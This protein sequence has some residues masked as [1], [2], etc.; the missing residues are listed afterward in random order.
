[1][2]TT[3]ANSVSSTASRTYAVQVDGS[4]DLVVNV[5]WVDTDTNTDTTYTAGTGLTLSGTQFSV[6][7][8]YVLNSGDSIAGQLSVT[9][10]AYPPLE[11]TRDA[12][13]VTTGNYGALK[14]N[15]ST[16]G[17]PQAGLGSYAG[18][19]VDDVIKG[20]VGFEND[21]SFHILNASDADLFTISSSG[22]FGINDSTP[23]YKL[24]INGASSGTVARITAPSSAN[25]YLQA[26]ASSADI[27]SGNSSGNA[28][29]LKIRPSG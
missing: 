14:L 25:I 8:N 18:F 6:Q 19:F 1:V 16:T 27:V 12:G 15:T 11:V 21:G 28:G 17:T 22:N 9:S 4:N 10:S 24:D 7:D 26:N 13:A 29:P 23:S 20:S 2:Q 3:G 5:P